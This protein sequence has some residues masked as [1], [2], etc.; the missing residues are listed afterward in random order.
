MV[1]ESDIVIARHDDHGHGVTAAKHGPKSS[2]IFFP[3]LVVDPLAFVKSVA[4]EKD[5]LRARKEHEKR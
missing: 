5:G 2:Q 1:M 3:F 4:Q